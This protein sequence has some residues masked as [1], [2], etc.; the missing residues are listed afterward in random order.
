MDRQEKII[1]AREPAQRG[2][3]SYRFEAYEGLQEAGL[4]VDRQNY[5]L[6][7]TAP[8]DGK[9]TLED[10]YRTFNLDRPAD[11]TVHPGAAQSRQG[12]AAVPFHRR[13]IQA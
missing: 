4:A 5:D 9:T 7:Y 8:L 2:G 3:F 11:F 6:V 1:L 13:V 10:I 12:G